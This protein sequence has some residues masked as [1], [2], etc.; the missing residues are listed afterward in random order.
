MIKILL[1]NYLLIY[2]QMFA[3]K[4]PY[5]GKYFKDYGI[6]IEPVNIAMYHDRHVFLSIAVKDSTADIN[7]PSI[8]NCKN[9]HVVEDFNLKLQLL[10]LEHLSF[11]NQLPSTL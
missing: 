2:Q 3:L 1:F 8:E 9:Q 7:Y 11:L 6:L 10:K 5:T 4:V